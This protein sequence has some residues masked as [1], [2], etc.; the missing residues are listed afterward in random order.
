MIGFNIICVEIHPSICSLWQNK[1]FWAVHLNFF[2]LIQRHPP[3]KFF[4]KVAKMDQNS[5]R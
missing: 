1:M 4:Y 3:T 5:V 2:W